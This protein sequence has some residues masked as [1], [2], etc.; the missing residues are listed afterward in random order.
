MRISPKQRRNSAIAFVLIVLATISILDVTRGSSQ[1]AATTDLGARIASLRVAPETPSG[2]RRSL[3]PHWDELQNGCSVREQVLRTESRVTP[4]VDRRTCK[5]SAGSW[6]STYDGKTLSNPS[7]VDIDHVVALKEA[8]DS[9]ARSWSPAKRRA[10]A[11]D[12]GDERALI[13][14]SA[15]ANR[16]KSDKDPAQWLPIPAA[17]CEYVSNWVAVKSRWGLSIDVV[18]KAALEKVAATCGPSA[19]V[20]TTPSTTP[21]T[22]RT[23]PTSSVFYATC[24][25]ARAAGAAPLRAGTPGYRVALDRDRDG[26]A[27]E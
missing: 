15:R 7:E 17:R 18:E 13:A 27:C 8:W 14:V 6:F 16:A 2:Y 9:G 26:I 25:A 3:F 11:N 20:P 10:Y 19:P 12:L 5:I 22:S 1:A 21:S 23:A 24:A 4:T